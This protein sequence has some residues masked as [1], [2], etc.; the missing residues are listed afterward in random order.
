MCPRIVD[1]YRVVVP[2]EQLHRCLLA[3][4]D[5]GVSIIARIA[6]FF[7]QWKHRR[8]PACHCRSEQGNMCV[9]QTARAISA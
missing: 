9:M 2:A 6:V 5:A 8:K 7:L 4:K 3:T 1:A